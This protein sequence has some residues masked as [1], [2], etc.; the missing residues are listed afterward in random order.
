VERVCDRV[1]II[2]DG[3]L[4]TVETIE[5]LLDKRFR[6]ISLGFCEPV[7]PAPFAKIPGVS[8]VSVEGNTISMR[9]TDSMDPIVKL[10]AQHT[11]ADLAVERPSLEEVFLT[12]YGGAT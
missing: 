7:D 4:I 9:A 12:Y 11:L 10:A 3:K 6:L 2:R 5:S 1:G 8:E